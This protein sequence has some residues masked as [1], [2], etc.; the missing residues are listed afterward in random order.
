MS[1]EHEP[2]T[3][4]IALEEHFALPRRVGAREPAPLDYESSS[5]VVTSIAR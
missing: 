3:G 1:S 4:N 2:L 5:S